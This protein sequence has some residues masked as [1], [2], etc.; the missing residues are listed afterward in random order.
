MNSWIC[1]EGKRGYKERQGVARSRMTAD[2]KLGRAVKV[3]QATSD[4]PSQ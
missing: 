3:K 1:I 4:P 2:I